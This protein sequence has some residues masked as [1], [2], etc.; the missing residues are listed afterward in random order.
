MQCKEV[1]AVLEKEGFVPMPQTARAHIASCHSCQSLVA[2]LTAIVATAHLLPAEAEPPAH[3]WT[4]LRT[5]LERENIIRASRESLPWWQGFSQLFRAR[6]LAT[7]ALG[8]LII[9]AAVLQI[10]H[11][12]TLSETRN[13]AT[14][15]AGRTIYDDTSLALTSDEAQLP[16][17]RTRASLVDVSLRRNLDIVDNFIADCERRVK[18]EPQDDLAREY[19]SGAYQQKAELLSVM[20]E[21][22]GGR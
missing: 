5:Q 8:F 14:V 15:P 4:N 16:P 21:R 20:M 9:A 7:A 3:L 18:Q 6:A 17:Q 11:S 22:E 19:L 12:A 13:V 2:D 10:R 1:E